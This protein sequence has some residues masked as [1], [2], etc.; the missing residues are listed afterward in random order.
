[1][2]KN[3]YVPHIYRISEL[4]ARLYLVGRGYSNIIPVV[5]VRIHRQTYM[6]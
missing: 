5:R 6:P 1:M 3:K 4:C 2:Q